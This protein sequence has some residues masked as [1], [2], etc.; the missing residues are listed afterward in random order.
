MTTM[1]VIVRFFFFQAEDGIRYWSVTG[2]QTCALPIS[3]L[4]E[5]HRLAT[6]ICRTFASR[7]SSSRAARIPS[8]EKRRFARCLDRKSV[9]VGK[10][11][12]HRWWAGHLKN[13]EG[14]RKC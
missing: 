7:C 8:E 10:E 4:D 3:A 9:V 14:Q 12:R 6:V 2:V 1:L 13:K 5:E 11:G